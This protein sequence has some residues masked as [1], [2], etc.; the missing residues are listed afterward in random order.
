MVYQASRESLQ[1]ALARQQQYEAEQA[2]LAELRRKQAETE[3]REREREIAE[4]AA[5]QARQ[6]AEQ[7]AEDERIAAA[8]KVRVK[9]SWGRCCIVM[10][11][12]SIE[13]FGLL[14]TN[15]DVCKLFR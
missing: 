8:N 12:H 6:E 15:M 5:Q 1:T 4:Q 14:Y 2:E 9:E 11:I 13:N 7:R 10:W 3:Q